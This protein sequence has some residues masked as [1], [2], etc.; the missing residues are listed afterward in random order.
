M[1]RKKEKDQRIKHR[2]S[3]IRRNGIVFNIAGL[4]PLI[5]GAIII[6]IFLWGVIISFTQPLYYLDH[7]NDFFMKKFTLKNYMNV[8]QNLKIQVV[9]PNG[10]YRYVNYLELF[11]NSCW[12]SIGSMAVQLISVVCFS[13]AVARF[14]FPGKKLLYG[15]L[16]LQM[17]LPIYG[18]LAANYELLARFNMIDNFAYLLAQ[19]AGHGMH[20]MILYSFFQNLP[21]GYAEAAKMDGAGPFTI[22]FKVMLPLSKSMILA[23]GTM[24]FMA[25]WQDYSNILIF[26]PSHPT[27]SAAMYYLRNQAHSLGLNTPSYFA[28]IIITALPVAIL[29]I[30]FNKDIM[31]NMTIGGL[32]G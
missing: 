3:E 32:K 14:E 23:L 21:S 18:Q 24:I 8:F 5:W 25:Y 6:G 10:A 11:F 31:K 26:Q 17:M 9:S 15:F 2:V 27:M 19:G 20:F 1:N 7:M 22:F 29:F 30:C 12:Y 16:V 4:L 28:G 13:Y